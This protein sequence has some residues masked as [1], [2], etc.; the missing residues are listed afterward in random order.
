VHAILIYLNSDFEAGTTDFVCRLKEDG[1]YHFEGTKGAVGDALIFRHEL[2][3]RGGQ[4]L[5]GV[6]YILR[7]DLGFE[8][9]APRSG[10]VA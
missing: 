10:S 6:K 2:L 7:L 5:S 1:Q 3:H 9:E 4:V 8:M